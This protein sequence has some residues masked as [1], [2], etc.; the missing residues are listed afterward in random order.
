MPDATAE[1]ASDF[2]PW[3]M[4]PADS[5]NAFSPGR[6]ASPFAQPPPTPMENWAVDLF[7]D[8][9]F[10]RE[11]TLNPEGK[12]T[13]SRQSTSE[14]NPPGAPG[15][16]TINNSGQTV[17]PAALSDSA[18]SSLINCTVLPDQALD[19]D[20]QIALTP[21]GVQNYTISIESATVDTIKSILEILLKTRTPVTIQSNS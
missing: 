10:L 3:T 13:T 16:Y 15:P 18:P 11:D 4:S 21:G 7:D 1:E 12:G 20:G 17:S 19:P 6:E 14:Q 2:Y 8:I 5:T 9:G